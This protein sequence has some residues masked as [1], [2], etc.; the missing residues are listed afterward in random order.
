MVLE[1]SL[2]VQ[3]RSTA[4]VPILN[5]SSIAQLR[6]PERASTLVDG[7][8]APLQQVVGSR[9]MRQRRRH[10][11]CGCR[12]RTASGTVLDLDPAG[13]MSMHSTAP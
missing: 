9:G 10:S 7:H 11:D 2:S 6:L 8:A 13:P 12:G 3:Q 4:T 1:A 5:E